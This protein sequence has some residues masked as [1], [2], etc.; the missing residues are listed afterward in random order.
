MRINAVVGANVRR[1]GVNGV[2]RVLLQEVVPSR[3]FG[4][5]ETREDVGD[6]S[7]QRRVFETHLHR[8]G[9]KGFLLLEEHEG[10]FRNGRRVILHRKTKDFELD[11]GGGAKTRDVQQLAAKSWEG[12]KCEAKPL[13]KGNLAYQRPPSC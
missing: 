7:R 10:E 9:S 1:N 4:N 12:D 5:V 13:E 11:V 8:I 6:H 3:P 2:R